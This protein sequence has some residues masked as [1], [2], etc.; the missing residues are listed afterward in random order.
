[1]SGQIENKGKVMSHDQSE[2]MGVKPYAEIGPDRTSEEATKNVVNKL[3]KNKKGSADTAKGSTT[4]EGEA[5]N[6]ISRK[7]TNG[8]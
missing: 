2:L 4:E 8:L 7:Q 1:M 6:L 5:A 3:K